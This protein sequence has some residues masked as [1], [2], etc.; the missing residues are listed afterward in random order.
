[1]DK[2]LVAQRLEELQQLVDTYGGLT[3]LKV[4]QQ[5]SHPDYRLYIG[6]WKLQEIKEDMTALDA[7]VLIIGNILK[8]GQIYN[9]NKEM[10]KIG[11]QA[12]DRVDLILKIF[13]R[14][15]QSMEARLQIQLASI[16]HMGPR[17]FGMGMEMSRQWWGSALARGLGETNTEIM[18]R[19]LAKKI[20]QIEQ[21][22]AQYEQVRATNRQARRKKL[23]PTVW[24]VGYTNAGK[25]SLM[26]SLTHKWVLVEN[27]L[28]AT[29]GTSVWELYFP[30][31]TWKG[32]KIL[33]NDTIGFM[34]D[35]PPSLIQAF[36]STL[37]DSIEADVL[38]H[39]VDVSDPLMQD[40]I[41]I[42]NSILDDIGAVQPRILVHN[43]IDLLS[44]AQCKKLQKSQGNQ[45]IFC[46]GVSGE[47][48]DDLK[49][50]L[51]QELVVG[52]I[53]QLSEF[54]L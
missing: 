29:L 37:E 47:G 33:V 40:K 49:K 7:E 39:V 48:I 52:E 17:I 34:R 41:N 32:E 36:R 51:Y 31:E 4:I 10:E 12:W 20:K 9:V 21:Q 42:V 43:K 13:E 14:H 1:M 53:R 8:P 22:L 25:S 30:S 11:K 18:K 46:S 23:L 28:F 5:K 54:S 3:V 26:N 19:H 27:K 16:K 50:F 15:A 45:G 44:P 24:L 35:L 6:S 38:L 2:D